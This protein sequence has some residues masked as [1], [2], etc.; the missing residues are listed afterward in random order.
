MT[1][2]VN[3]AMAEADIIKH[4]N[5]KGIGISALETLPQGG[6]RLVCSSVDGAEQVRTKLRRLMIAGD[7]RRE[8]FRPRTPLW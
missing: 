2:A 1:R 5:D 3:L 6:V 7:P 8:K 4:C